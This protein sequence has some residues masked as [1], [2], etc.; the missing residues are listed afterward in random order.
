MRKR[1]LIIVLAT[2]LCGCATEPEKNPPAGNASSKPGALVI[3]YRPDSVDTFAATFRDS[4]TALS[5]LETAVNARQIPFAKKSYPFGTLVEQVGPRHNGD[6]GYWLYKVNGK[7]V[8]EASNAHRV[9]F[10]DT[11]TFFF[12]ER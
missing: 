10:S 2:L 6:G 12:D 5:W 8:P 1:A 7:P 9:A 11:V 3:A 4:V